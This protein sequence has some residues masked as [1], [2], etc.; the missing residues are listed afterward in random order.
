MPPSSYRPQPA[1]PPA[2]AAYEQRKL[3]AAL[4]VA[5]EDLAAE[6][7]KSSQDQLSGYFQLA[8]DE[9]G[10]LQLSSRVPSLCR[11]NMSASVM[12]VT[13]SSRPCPTCDLTPLH[14][15]LQAV[16]P[17][18]AENI[19]LST[20]P[21]EVLYAAALAG[22]SDFC[23]SVRVE[24]FNLA[25][26]DVMRSEIGGAPN[27]GCRRLTMAAG[28]GQSALPP[29]CV[30]L[31]VRRQISLRRNSSAPA[32]LGACHQLRGMAGRGETAA[33]RA[34]AMMLARCPAATPSN[35]SKHEKSRG[36][37]P[38]RWL[39]I[40]GDSVAYNLVGRIKSVFL[41][42]HNRSARGL[43]EETR[44]VP[45]PRDRGP[46]RWVVWRTDRPQQ[47]SVWV[48][49]ESWYDAGA[50]E[51]GFPVGIQTDNAKLYSTL[52]AAGAAGTAVYLSFGSHSNGRVSG[53]FVAE[54]R[55]RRALERL[56]GTLPP[57]SQLVLALQ[58]A[59][60]L[61]VP[62][63][64]SSTNACYQTN[65]RVEAQGRAQ[66]R[67]LHDVCRSAGGEGR[68]LALSSAGAVLSA[69]STGSSAHARGVRCRVLDL[70]SATVPHIFD[71]TVFR[72]G[73]PVHFQ[74]T[75]PA[76]YTI[77]PMIAAAFA[78]RRGKILERRNVVFR[79]TK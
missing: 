24:R 64:F 41:Q 46:P 8:H 75:R 27:L 57:H 6:K 55:Y 36:R 16:C 17:R 7:A 52:Q 65:L 60:G 79:S 38:G 72:Q 67:A 43:V 47:N 37:V 66:A 33:E 4:K 69:A 74:L 48:S 13:V 20:I 63:R 51:I 54:Q 1:R 31:A 68:P 58:S 40:I 42:L 76:A 35:S 62:S 61:G 28:L 11:D 50:R 30:P 5:R 2:A 9:K 21:D 59:W 3:V 44:A 39:R 45:Q 29:G 77:D 19:S 56:V 18:F 10:G 12:H 23:A 26:D 25:L 14:S 71:P 34:A 53:D 22:S 49:Y 78:F 73:D 15:S 70:F 32:L